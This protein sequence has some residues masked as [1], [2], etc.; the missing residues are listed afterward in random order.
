[1]IFS[2][3][4]FLLASSS[5][6]GT[7]VVCFFLSCVILFIA[8]KTFL[9][10]PEERRREL[11]EIEEKQQKAE[12]LLKKAEQSKKEAESKWSFRALSI[13]REIAERFDRKMVAAVE[14]KERQ[15][16]RRE[17]KV[18][19]EQEEV[20]NF[21]AEA[22]AASPAWLAKAISDYEQLRYETELNWSRYSIVREYLESLRKVNHEKR[23]EMYFARYRCLLYESLFPELLKYAGDEYERDS[24]PIALEKTTDKDWLTDE[25]YA[26]LSSTER[27]QL[28][29]DRYITSHRKTKWQIGRDYELFIGYRYRRRHFRVEYVGMEKR[30]EDMGR[31]LICRNDPLSPVYETHIVQCKYWSQEKQIHEKH[32]MQLFGTTVEYA[33]ARGIALENGRL[34]PRLKPVLVTSTKLSD[35]AHRFADALGVEYH[36]NIDFPSDPMSY[37]RIKCN[38]RSGIY[39]LPFDEQYDATKIVPSKGDC[40][41]FTVVEAESMGFTRARRHFIHG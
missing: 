38:K 4:L 22:K 16:E 41:A 10:I 13:E 15:I 5:V 19:K 11:A 6:S 7:S 32:V 31:D 2:S 24:V 36:E 28:A 34:P 40:F 35:T 20:R 26:S 1:M 12:E 30:L 9:H 21:I 33:F 23:F 39:H 17:E 25:E 18:K 8:V 37:P 29:L 27:S 3:S 14:D